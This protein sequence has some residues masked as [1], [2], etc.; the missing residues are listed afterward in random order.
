[1]TVDVSANA[2]VQSGWERRQARTRRDV[3]AA[4]GELIAADGLDGL[5]MR[6]LA[7]RAGVAVATLY[8]QFGDRDG[9]LVAFVSNGLDQL[10]VD[11]DEQPERGPIE[12]TRALFRAL[13]DTVGS[14]VD[15]WRPIFASLK[16]GPGSHG[17]GS[18]GDRVVHII[19]HDLARAATESMF[20]GECDVAR[21]ARH[22]FITRM[23][24]LEKWATGAIEWDWYRES[25]ELGLELTLAAVLAS[26][27][28][29][30]AA[31]RSSG[32]VT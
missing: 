25:S 20:V 10:E 22:I 17:M 27:T 11:F 19:E 2:P 3:L 30:L 26:P 13:D 29:R 28:E 14:A 6:K 7:S 4:A 9:V 18:V 31:L 8:N 32:I 15:I 23:N 24:R 12:A 5:T 1:M 21:L 16:S